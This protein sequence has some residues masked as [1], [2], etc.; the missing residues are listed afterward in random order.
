MVICLA[1]CALKPSSPA[2]LLSQPLPDWRY[3]DVRLLDAA[4]SALET[5]DVIALYTRE[6]YGAAQ[7]R[8]DYLDYPLS[9]DHDLHVFIFAHVTDPTPATLLHEAWDYQ[10]LI[11]AGGVPQLVALH[12][13]QLH[14]T[15]LRVERDS[16]SDQVVITFQAESIRHNLS[17]AQISVLLTSPGGEQILDEISTTAWQAAPPPRQ[18]VVLGFW[19]TFDAATPAQALRRWNGAHTG[20]DSSRHGL[21]ALLDAVERTHLPVTIF[22]LKTPA[23]LSALDHLGALPRIQKLAKHGLLILPDVVPL[24][25]PNPPR[26]NIPGL[27]FAQVIA[28]N[29]RIAANFGLPASPL[30]CQVVGSGTETIQCVSLFLDENSEYG[31]DNCFRMIGDYGYAHYLNP[32]SEIYSGGLTQNTKRLLAN[33]AA[34]VIHEALILGGDL[35]QSAWG[36]PEAAYR[37]LAYFAEHPWLNVQDAKDQRLAIYNHAPCDSLDQSVEP[38]PLY[39]P[40]G[41]LLK[42]GLNSVQL[43]NHVLSE[44]RSA[45]PGSFTTLAWQMYADLL[46]QGSEALYDLRLP[47]LG[48]IGHLLRAERWTQNPQAGADCTQDLDWDGMPECI[49]ASER[50]FMVFESEGGGV[51]VAAARSYDRTLQVLAPTFQFFVGLDDPSNWD[52]TKGIAGDPA[53]LFAFTEITDRWVNFEPQASTG[54]ITFSLQG[55][56]IKRY[57]LTKGG[58]QVTF[59][60]DG[61]HSVAIPVA[62]DPGSRF[63]QD[64]SRRL[65]STTTEHAW[66]WAL[67]STLT[68]QVETNR[69]IIPLAFNQSQ[70]WMDQPEDPNLAY[71]PGH[72]TL[73]PLGLVRVEGQGP[74]QIE[75]RILDP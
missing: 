21:S 47:Y 75:L 51:T 6:I 33:T 29:Q 50:F 2:E 23:N 69:Q 41:E 30:L 39:A 4:D 44:L 62:I 9:P 31:R 35:A 43:H 22:D 14:S 63:K 67:E 61:F 53:Q 36:E 20:P 48:E 59:F 3:A 73:F 16:V 38:L 60:D 27:I 64:W 25:S 11:P 72:Y 54:E 37:A 13:Q 18:P 57:E 24:A 32:N 12:S 15:E 7:I 70:E 28:E 26:L 40:N 49:L 74:L 68:V 42:S 5:A 34:G 1:G 46:D 56:P 17:T 71:P 10:I 52:R 58:V 65:D 19:N 8:L 55:K 45:P 66:R